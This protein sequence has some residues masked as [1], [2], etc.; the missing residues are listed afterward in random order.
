MA[1]DRIEPIAARESQEAPPVVRSRFALDDK[2]K[3][4]IIAI[5]SVGCSRVTAARYVGCHPVTI[6]RTAAREPSFAAQIERAETAHEILHLQNIN[7]AGKEGRYWRASAWALERGY[8]NRYAVRSAQALTHEQVSLALVQFAAVIIEEVPE[9]E[10]RKKILERLDAMTAEL[11]EDPLPT[12]I[13]E[14]PL[15]ANPADEG[16]D[17]S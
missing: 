6:R 15:P 16:A 9:P 10:R 8:P 14:D 17:E 4:E 1:D 13:V 2:K 3:T 12:E 11:Q 7:A 5:L